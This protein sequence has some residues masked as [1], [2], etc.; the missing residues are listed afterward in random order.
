MFHESIKSIYIVF[1]TD[2]FV[3]NS[4]FASDNHCGLGLECKEDAN[5]EIALMVMKFN[6]MSQTHNAQVSNA[7]FK[8]EY[9]IMLHLPTKES[10][11]ILHEIQRCGSDYLSIMTKFLTPILVSHPKNDYSS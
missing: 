3:T 8:V 10:I 2:V 1:L 11:P 6:N 7:T 9:P 4:R 5:V